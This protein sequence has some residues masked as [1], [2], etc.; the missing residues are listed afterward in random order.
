VGPLI[1]LPSYDDK[2]TPIRLYENGSGVS[3]D[4]FKVQRTSPR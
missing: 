1:R 4:Y 3:Q 2:A